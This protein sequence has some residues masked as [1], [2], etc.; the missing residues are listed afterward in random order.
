LGRRRSCL[1][2][3]GTLAAA[4]FRFL[5]ETV[6]GRGAVAVAGATAAGRRRCPRRRCWRSSGGSRCWSG[7]RLSSRSLGVHVQTMHQQGLHLVLRQI[8]VGLLFGACASD[9]GQSRF[10]K[11]IVIVSDGFRTEWRR[12]RC[13][14]VV[15]G[16]IVLIRIVKC[17]LLL[18]IY[19]RSSR[20]RRAD[21]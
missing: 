18:I 3:E 8:Y 9:P 11:V 2:G 4:Q 16:T 14:E 5:I 12:S 15:I 6:R 21:C 17:L 13:G 7:L 20:R 1:I 10:H 19:R